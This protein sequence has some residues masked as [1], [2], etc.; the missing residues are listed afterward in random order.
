MKEKTEFSKPVITE[1][2]KEFIEAHNIPLD[3]FLKCITV[4]I[5]SQKNITRANIDLF[6]FYDE[7]K[8]EPQKSI[9][10]EVCVD[11]LTTDE[12]VEIMFKLNKLLHI[13][14]HDLPSHF[15]YRCSA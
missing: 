3:T 13:A 6:E 11:G 15:I 1:K 7:G 14:F 10:I 9:S 4:M 8:C 12:K 2:A 5:T